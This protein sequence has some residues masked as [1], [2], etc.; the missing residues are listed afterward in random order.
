MT[1]LL[2]YN[3]FLSGFHDFLANLGEDSCTLIHFF[4][5]RIVFSSDG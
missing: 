5:K 2:N 4:I 1:E 3:I